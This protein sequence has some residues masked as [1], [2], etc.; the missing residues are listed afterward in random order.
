MPDSF[1]GGGLALRAVFNTH[2][3]AK[4]LPELAQEYS[5]NSQIDF[6]CGFSKE[7]L[8]AGDL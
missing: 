6:K 8:Q 7:Y 1:V 3:W 4:L 5:V 2:L